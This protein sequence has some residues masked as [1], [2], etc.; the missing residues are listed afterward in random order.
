MKKKVWRNAVYINFV[1][2]VVIT[3]RLFLSYVMLMFYLMNFHDSVKKIG[4]ASSVCI[5]SVA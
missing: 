2:C 5:E 3:L 4:L 1:A